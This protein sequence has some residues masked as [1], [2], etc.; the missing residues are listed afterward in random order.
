MRNVVYIICSFIVLLLIWHNYEWCPTPNILEYKEVLAEESTHRN[1]SLPSCFDLQR[2]ILNY[3][4]LNVFIEPLT[5][6]ER[7]GVVISPTPSREFLEIREALASYQV[8]RLE[9]ACFVVPGVDFLNLNR[10]STVVWNN[11]MSLYRQKYQNAV[12]F[13]FLGLSEPVQPLIAGSLLPKSLYRPQFDISIP[14]LLPS[15][16][17]SQSNYY[18]KINL[19]I[20]TSANQY[21]PLQFDSIQN[22]QAIFS[23]SPPSL[24]TVCNHKDQLQRENLIEHVEQSVFVLI[25]ESFPYLEALLSI[26]LSSG[27]IPIIHLPQHVLP[28]TELIDW[29]KIALLPM[30]LSS[31]SKMINSLDKKEIEDMSNLGRT[32]YRTH[33]SSAKIIAQQTFNVFEKRI[34]P[35]KYISKTK[36]IQP[37]LPHV[38]P[39]NSTQLIFLASN[40][41]DSRT[42]NN[43]CA[44]TDLKSVYFIW[45]S[46]DFP[47]DASSFNCKSPVEVLLGLQS[48]SQFRD[49]LLQFSSASIMLSR[50]KSCDLKISSLSMSFQT[51]RENPEV[52]VELRTDETCDPITFMHKFYGLKLTELDFD[53]KSNFNSVLTGLKR[54]ELYEKQ[55]KGVVNSGSA[56]VLI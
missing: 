48:W 56:L 36:Q 55:V 24:L 45:L 40:L 29:Q 32:I 16:L 17:S 15:G 53:M 21:E 46:T 4:N 1:C 51:W 12:I 25:S 41:D 6:V 7:E 10:F 52:V 47:P 49:A 3:D 28:F 19:L 9:D 34:L 43:L 13:N 20:P 26:S 8:Q 11:V 37:M 2:C 14:F 42:L 5:E 22:A 39:S 44:L 35:T 30:T 23:C 38:S 27:T 54:L 50:G 18:R 31:L 33:F